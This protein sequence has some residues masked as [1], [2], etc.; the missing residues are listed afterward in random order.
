MPLDAAAPL[1][2]SSFYKFVALPDPDHVVAVL[3]ELVSPLTGS[4]LVA[5]EGISGALAAEA[6][7]LATFEHAIQHDERLHGAFKGLSLIH[8]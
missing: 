3:R 5:E 8:I 1:I 6:S 4:I 7:A 2:H